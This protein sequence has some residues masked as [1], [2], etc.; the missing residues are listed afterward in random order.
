MDKKLIGLVTGDLHY[1]WWKSF[2]DFGERT[3]VTTDFIAELLQVSVE[4]DVPIFH[5]G[6]MFHTPKG[7]T[8]KTL[9]EFMIMMATIRNSYESVKIYG[10]T[11][12][13][14]KDS[15]GNLWAAMCFAFPDIFTNLDNSYHSF[16]WGTVFG[17]PYTK[18]NVG[19]VK[20]ITSLA[21][22][23]AEKKII[24]LHTA[25]YGAP[26]PSGY[27]LEPQNLP[28]DLHALFKAFD[29]VLAGHVHKHT[30]VAKNIYMVGAPNQQRKS[31]AGCTMGYLEMYDDFSV[32]FIPYNAPQYRYYKEGEEHEDTNDFWIEIPKPKKIKK[33]S[34]AEFK[35][36]MDKTEMAKM[37]AKET[38]VTSPR[39]IQALIDVLNKTDE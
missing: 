19:L 17:L 21:T 28:R 7:L 35:S 9:Y 34:E 2:N 10:I 3:L 20:K 32:K 6:D 18:R 15:E 24:L 16:V 23:P 26:D 37:Y 27:E 31:D 30:K 4:K 33:Q 5:T 39:K 1:H 36:T 25:L 11:G 12:N 29:L 38:G 8:T 14:D 13:H 22:H